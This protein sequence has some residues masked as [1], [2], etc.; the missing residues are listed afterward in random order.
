MANTSNIPD[1]IM[2]T[3][4]VAIAGWV[5]PGAGYFLVKQKKKAIS[6]FIS[7]TL[8]FTIGIFVGSIGVV[9]KVSAIWWYYPQ[10]AFSPVVG[11]LGQITVSG[12]YPVYGRPEEL[13]QLYTGLAGLPNL[14]CIFKAASVA[15]HGKDV[16]EDTGKETTE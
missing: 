13:G 10:M 8:M 6:V 1:K 7:L 3:I 11:F 4:A 14:V 15:M 12:N 9:D 16:F 2:F 5:L